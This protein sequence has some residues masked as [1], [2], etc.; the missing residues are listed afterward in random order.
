MRPQLQVMSLHAGVGCRM[1]SECTLRKSAGSPLTCRLMNRTK[2]KCG[3]KLLRAN[4]LQPLTDLPTISL[5]QDAIQELCGNT[6]LASDLKEML[7][8]LPP[9]LD[10]LAISN[11]VGHCSGHGS[12]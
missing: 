5:R 3:A 1:L 12:V 6:E 7:G 2:T 9:D 10:R 11:A 8:Q 4:L